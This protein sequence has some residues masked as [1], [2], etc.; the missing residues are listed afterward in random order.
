MP[1]QGKDS[2]YASGS[3]PAPEAAQRTGRFSDNSALNYFTN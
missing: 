2:S 3:S 1:T